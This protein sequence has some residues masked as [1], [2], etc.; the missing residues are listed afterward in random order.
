L[1]RS[2]TKK[3]VLLHSHIATIMQVLLTL[4]QLQPTTTMNTTVTLNTWSCLGTTHHI[5]SSQLLLIIL[6][7]HCALSVIKLTKS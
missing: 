5:T 1:G 3:R 2:A 6:V 4:L 7:L